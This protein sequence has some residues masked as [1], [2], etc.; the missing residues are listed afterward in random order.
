MTG[1]NRRSPVNDV[2]A[3]ELSLVVDGQ[4]DSDLLTITGS[5]VSTSLLPPPDNPYKEMK[6]E[7]MTISAPHTIRVRLTRPTEPSK[8]V[9]ASKNRAVTSGIEWRT[10]PGCIGG[11]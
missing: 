1:H 6:P 9:A 10:V 5:D 2:R 3:R 11:R 8:R 7:E 4:S